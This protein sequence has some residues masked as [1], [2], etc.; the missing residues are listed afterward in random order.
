MYF[1][2]QSFIR[3]AFANIFPHSLACHF[4][5]LAVSFIMQNFKILIK[6]SLSIISFTYYTF[7]FVSESVSHSVMSDCLLPHSLPGSS[8]HGILQARRL[9]WVAIPF[10]RGSSKPRD[11]TQSPTLGADSL[12]SEPP[13]KKSLPNPRW[14]RLS[15]CYFLGVL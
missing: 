13:G 3:Y 14:A 1:G 11:Q 9:E 4:I 15:P 2:Q 6:S 10:S 7:G 5:L 12:L 8:V